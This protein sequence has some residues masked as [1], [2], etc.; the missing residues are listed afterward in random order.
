MIGGRTGIL[1]C[2][3]PAGTDRNVCP[4]GRFRRGGPC[5]LPNT[6]RILKENFDLFCVLII[7]L[8]KQG[9]VL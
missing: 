8:L 3:F 4:T 9:D 7:M 6:G 1:A 2:S 5:A